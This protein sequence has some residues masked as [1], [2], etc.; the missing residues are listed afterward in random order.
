MRARR[1][2]NNHHAVVEAFVN[3]GWTVEDVT[4]IDN[5]CD[6]QVSKPIAR[7]VDGI[8]YVKAPWAWVEVKHGNKKLT[9]GETA[10]EQKCAINKTPYFIVRSVDE[11]Q[12]VFKEILLRDAL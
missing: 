4:A 7:K 8:L 11:V 5:F 12:I 1:K 3:L 10:F 9:K 2:D 6:I